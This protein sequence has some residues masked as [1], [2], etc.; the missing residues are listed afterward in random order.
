MTAT[1]E[2]LKF[3]TGIAQRY[4][5]LLNSANRDKPS[6]AAFIAR[7]DQIA[8]MI[9]DWNQNVEAL[10]LDLLACASDFDLAHDVSGIVRNDRLQSA[11]FALAY[12]KR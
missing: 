9:L 10:R 7:R 3:A 6:P 11:R 4:V 2:D 5:E 1:I 12:H 8:K